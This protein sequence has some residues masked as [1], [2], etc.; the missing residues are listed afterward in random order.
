MR[1]KGLSI[2]AI[3]TKTGYSVGTVH[4]HAKDIEASA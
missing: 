1:A 2:R 4:R 3:A